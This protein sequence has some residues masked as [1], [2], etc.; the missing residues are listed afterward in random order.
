MRDFYQ[1]SSAPPHVELPSCPLCGRKMWLSRI[2][3]EKPDHDRRTFE[4]ATCNHS[5][6][7][8][9]KFK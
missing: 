6:S 3:P 1:G 7:V 9:V 4:C 5:E 2:E 8:V